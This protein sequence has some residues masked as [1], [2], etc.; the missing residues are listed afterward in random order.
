MAVLGKA[1]PATR[2]KKAV[3]TVGKKAHR[4]PDL[5]GNR[6]PYELSGREGEF[7][8]FQDDV[9]DPLAFPSIGDVDKAVTCL[10]DSGI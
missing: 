6:L 4:A 3:K 9:F 10:D 2:I 8:H 5:S 1:K 7:C